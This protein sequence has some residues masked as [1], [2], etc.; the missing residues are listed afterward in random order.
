MIAFKVVKETLFK[1]YDRDKAPQLTAPTV[2]AIKI[3][4][5]GPVAPMREGSVG[6]TPGY[7]NGETSEP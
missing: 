2:L 5:P 7:L 6:G 1:A 4:Q 3:E